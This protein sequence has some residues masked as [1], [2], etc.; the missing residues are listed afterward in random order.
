MN[1]PTEPPC[2]ECGEVQPDEKCLECEFGYEA[3]PDNDCS[4]DIAVAKADKIIRERS[5]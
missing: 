3:N 1:A 5:R 2:R 4:N